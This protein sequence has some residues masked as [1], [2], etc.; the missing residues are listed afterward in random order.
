M[1]EQNRELG[2]EIRNSGFCILPPR[3]NCFTNESFTEYTFLRRKKNEA[4]VVDGITQFLFQDLD[5]ATYN[6]PRT[7]E[8]SFR[9]SVPCDEYENLKIAS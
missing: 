1:N 7:R 5:S 6:V 2:I 4:L 9:Q 8:K 3:G